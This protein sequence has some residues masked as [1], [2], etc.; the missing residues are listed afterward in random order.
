MLTESFDLLY[1]QHFSEI[2]WLCHKMTLNKQDAE[3][4][5]EET[6]IKAYFNMGIFDSQK[7]SFR[8][9]LFTIAA[10][11]CRDFLK[12][13]SFKKHKQTDSID[14]QFD[15]LLTATHDNT[16]YEKEL[17]EMLERCIK[18]LPFDEKAAVTMYH[19]HG[20]VLQEIAQALGKNSPNSAKKRL[21]IAERK[22][23]ICLEQYG[24]GR[25]DV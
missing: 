18:K 16:I 2:Y 22:L 13:A 11:L 23:K 12:S 1:Q 17:L 10:N 20:L 14:D 4:L 19:L 8:T 21:K 7:G 15:E 5:A 24:F 3:E 6:F 9:W 25:A